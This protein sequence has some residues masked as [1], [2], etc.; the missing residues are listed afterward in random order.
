MDFSVNSKGARDD[1]P[2]RNIDVRVEK[3]IRKF[4]NNIGSLSTGANKNKPKTVHL[5]DVNCK[6]GEVL[7]TATF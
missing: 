3:E 6:C 4:I 5:A 1:D 2:S 7:L